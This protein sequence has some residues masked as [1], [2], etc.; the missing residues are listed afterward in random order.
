MLST[1]Q[2]NTRNASTTS[3]AVGRGNGP[4][5][6][7][8]R[9]VLEK[10]FED[11]YEDDELFYKFHS[12][13]VANVMFRTKWKKNRMTNMYD[14]YTDTSDE[15]FAFAVLENNAQRYLD[16]VDETKDDD[17]IALPK[18]TEARKK[19][20]RGVRHN[21]AIE[22]VNGIES[23]NIDRRDSKNLNGKGWSLEGR[24]RFARL[25][26]MVESYRNNFP[27]EVERLGLMCIDRYRKEYGKKSYDG[28]IV[29]TVVEEDYDAMAIKEREEDEWKNHLKRKSKRRKLIR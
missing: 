17:D 9:K 23:S 28:S 26:K 20:S 5:E 13:C 24:L 1:S 6:R 3:T 8:L 25:D 14:V 19:R 16:M 12:V 15:A 27:E 7:V 29:L 22:R 10:R 2:T 18:Y 21:T 11:I 4:M